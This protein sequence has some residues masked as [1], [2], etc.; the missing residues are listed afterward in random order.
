[1]EKYLNVE[2]AVST[3]PGKIR[4][5]NE[6]NFLFGNDIGESPDEPALKK[7]TAALDKPI[8]FGVFDGMGG[9]SAGE[10]ASMICA[11]SAQSA[12]NSPD[13]PEK[14]LLRICFAANDWICE[15][16]RG[17]VKKRMGSTASMLYFDKTRCVL[18]NIGD[19]PIFRYR[20]GKLERIFYEHSER[21]S[22]E[23]IHGK[24]PNLN[25]KFKLTQ[26]I[27]IFPHEEFLIEPYIKTFDIKCGDLFLICSDGLSDMVS[28]ERISKVASS[29]Q[30]PLRIAQRLRDLALESGGKDNI[31]IIAARVTNGKT[32]FAASLARVFKKLRRHRI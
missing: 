4:D 23:K 24:K 13:E 8:M 6:D 22:Y 12:A 20:N 11:R 27:G 16:M 18:C 17:S 10:R 21:E 1:M 7:L 29:G 5:K 2:A 19:S 32:D 9:I 28:D 30:E 25:G 26:H 3:H 15:E 31:T 14:L